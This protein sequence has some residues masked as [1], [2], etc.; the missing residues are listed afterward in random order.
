MT[1]IVAMYSKVML[2]FR[3]RRFWTYVEAGIFVVPRYAPAPGSSQLPCLAVVWVG[4]SAEIRGSL[5]PLANREGGRESLPA[6]V[7]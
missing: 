5:A 1:R 3:I 2:H 4:A 7:A 6:T